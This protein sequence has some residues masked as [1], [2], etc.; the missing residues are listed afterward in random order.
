[1]RRLAGDKLA[2][3]M[4][5]IERDYPEI[6]IHR[7]SYRRDGLCVEEILACGILNIDILSER[8][9]ERAINKAAKRT[10]GEITT[11]T[12]FSSLFY[13]RR[14]GAVVDEFSQTR[15]TVSPASSVLIGADRSQEKKKLS[16]LASA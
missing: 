12:R 5:L 2:C 8:E 13:V 16:G 11:N 4:R 14:V 3:V 1:M 6:F 7:I 10:S 15:I 9:R